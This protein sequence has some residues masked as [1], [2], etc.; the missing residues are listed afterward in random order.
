MKTVLLTKEFRD[1]EGVSEYCK[2][3]ATKLVEDEEEAMI[4]A[5]DDGSY[6]S[7]DDRVQVER[8]PLHFDGDNL[9]NWTMM[10]NNELKGA[11]KNMGDVDVIHANDWTTIPAGVALANHLDRPLVVTVH[12]TENERG[13]GG[14]HSGMISELEWKGVGSADRVLVTREDTKNSVIFDLDVPD[15][16]VEVINP[17]DDNW[18]QRVLSQ[19]RELLHTEEA[20]QK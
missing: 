6:Y 10:M 1:G 15:E 19:Y 12:S 20:V 14:E 2:N 11:V 17:F 3:I 9:Y 5:F 4:V 8:V 7:I 18:R 16:K 13:F